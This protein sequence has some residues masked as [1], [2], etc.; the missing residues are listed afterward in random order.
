VW[1]FLEIINGPGLIWLIVFLNTLLD[2]ISDSEHLYSRWMNWDRFMHF[3]GGATVAVVAAYVLPRWL[4]KLFPGQ[5][6]NPWLIVLL[7]FGTVSLAGLAYETWEYLVHF[8]YPWELGDGADTV[9]DQLFNLVG[10]LT[11][12][13]VQ[14]VW[15]R[16]KRT[17]PVA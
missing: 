1:F 10:S 14:R 16:V 5:K 12:L 9:D 2:S 8:K 11:V 17:E 7:V 3:A 15:A 13:V 4:R 6:I